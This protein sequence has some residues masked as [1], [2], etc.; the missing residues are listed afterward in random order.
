MEFLWNFVCKLWKITVSW[1]LG[2]ERKTRYVRVRMDLLNLFLQ[3]KFENCVSENF[4][5]VSQ[6]F[7]KF[8]RVFLQ[9]TT[10]TSQNVGIDFF[11]LY[12]RLDR[13]IAKVYAKFGRKIRTFGKTGAIYV[14]FQ[15]IQ[16]QGS[17]SKTLGVQKIWIYGV[18]QQVKAHLILLEKVQKRKLFEIFNFLV[19][20]LKIKIYVFS[21][22]ILGYRWANYMYLWSQVWGIQW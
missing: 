13:S 17:I 18:I 19:R 20:V 14:K 4:H 16:N 3:E 10:K 2:V 22:E 8:F 5:E 21:R 1:V 15:K 12:T 11:W 9:N 7:W 6:K